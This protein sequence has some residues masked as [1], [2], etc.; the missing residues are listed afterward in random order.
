MLSMISRQLHG[1][2]LPDVIKD[3]FGGR[4]RS[5]VEFNS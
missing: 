5:Q 2:F 3:D 4:F 1:S